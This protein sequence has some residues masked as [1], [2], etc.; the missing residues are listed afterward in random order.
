MALL[1]SLP[2]SLS[3][4]ALYSAVKNS[5]DYKR[6]TTTTTLHGPC[7]I[8]DTALCTDDVCFTFFCSLHANCTLISQSTIASFFWGSSFFISMYNR[9]KNFAKEIQWRQFLLIIHINL[10]ANL[11]FSIF[12][13]LFKW[14]TLS[15]THSLSLLVSSFIYLFI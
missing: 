5:I 8:Y 15:H 7:V 11:S 13:P 12:L 6:T 1:F 3:S 9:N 10:C 14:Q 2:P 4:I